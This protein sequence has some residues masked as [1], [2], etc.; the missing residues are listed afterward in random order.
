VRSADKEAWSAWVKERGGYL[1]EMIR[2]AVAEHMAAHR[3]DKRIR[4]W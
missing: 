2:Q 4:Y 1:S 3:T